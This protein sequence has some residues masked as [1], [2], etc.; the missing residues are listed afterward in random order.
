MKKFKGV[1]ARAE[2]LDWKNGKIYQKPDGSLY[3]GL[4][5]TYFLVFIYTFF[6]NL[7]FCLG[8]PTKITVMSDIKY[9]II[10]AAITLIMLLGVIFDFGKLN[11]AACIL[12]IPS[13]LFLGIMFGI[14]MRPENTPDLIFGFQP[15]F[16]WRHF[17]PLVVM[18]FLACFKLVIAIRALSKSNKSYKKVLDTL[19]ADFYNEHPDAAETDWLAFIENYEGKPY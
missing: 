2:Y 4:K 7:L 11:L 1:Q 14:L 5:I 8:Y 13:V 9:V 19:Y 3:E 15:S 12:S 16:L 18:L 17:I 6:I 10:T